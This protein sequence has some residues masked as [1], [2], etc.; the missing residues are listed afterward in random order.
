M[1]SDR[2]NALLQALEFTPDNPHL[3]S[4]LAETL[5]EEGDAAGAVEQYDILLNAGQLSREA[6][7]SA[8][9]LAV[10]TNSL[11]A[12]ARFLQAAQNAGVVEGVSELKASVERALTDHGVLRL[13]RDGPQPASMPGRD[14]LLEAATR[15]TFAD[16]GGLEGVKKTIHRMVIL[17]LQRPDL[18]QKYGR[19][20]GGGVMLYGPPGCGKTLLARATAGVNM[21]QR[22][23]MV[24]PLLARATAG[25]CGLPFYNIR[26]EDILDPWIGVS[27]S[28]LHEAFES[29]RRAAPCVVFIDELD[30]LAFA[31]RKQAGT[32]MRGLVDQMLQEL[33]SIGSENR[34]LLVL[35]ATNAPWDVDDGLKRP[36]RFDRMLFAP[37]PDEEARLHI[38]RI[39]LEGR[40]TAGVDLKR[41]AKATPLFSGADLRALVERAIDGVIEE[42]LDTGQEP[43][44]TTRHLDAARAEM[45]PTTLDWLASAR[46]YVEFANQAGRYDEVATFLRSREAKAYRD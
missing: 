8:G 35:S 16:V 28:N 36:G 32:S 26:I 17:P 46:N 21:W 4:M 38:L 39:L 5:R 20:A 15:K 24:G 3:R 19:Q 29:A 7:V 31:R 6:L 2:A 25:E 33:D 13:V 43:P 30:A 1:G 23:Y 9:E 45:R 42:A 34:D 27:E 41:L 37:P 10:K 11:D 18:Y 40:P 22:R 14:D 12:A 44:L